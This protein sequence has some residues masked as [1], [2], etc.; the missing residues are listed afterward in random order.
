MSN[1]SNILN[2]NKIW[3]EYI[4][5]PPS[6]D[7]YSIKIWKTLKWE[8]SQMDGADEKNDNS[9]NYIIQTNYKYG[10]KDDLMETWTEPFATSKKFYQWCKGGKLFLQE[11]LKDYKIKLLVNC[12]KRNMNIQFKIKKIIYNI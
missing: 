10:E 12:S 8:V 6:E 3:V 5:D 11:K 2:I 4:A 1:F 7:K 9:E